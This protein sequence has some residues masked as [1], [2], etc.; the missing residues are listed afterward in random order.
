MPIRTPTAL[1]LLVAMGV[2]A[3]WAAGSK[4]PKVLAEAQALRSEQLQLLEKI[5]NIDSGTGDVAGGIKVADVLIPRLKALGMTVDSV[6]AEEPDL[7]PNTVATLKGTGKGC[8]LMVGHIDTVFEPG[9]AQRRP[10]RTDDKRAY[11]P[12]VADEKAGVVEGIYAL[13]ILRKLG[14]EDFKQIVFLVETS[15]ERGSPGTRA[16]IGKLLADADVELNLEPG[17][18]PDKITVWRKGSAFFFINVKGRAAHSGIAPQEGRNA[19]VELIHQLQGIEAFPHSGEGITV[20]LTIMHAGTR[21]N[22]IP[23]NATAEINLRVRDPADFDRVEQV[24]RRNAET[25]IVPDTRVTV[26]RATAFPPFPENPETN[27]LAALA[28]S[29]YAGMGRKLETGWNGGASE[30]GLAAEAG[31]PALDG[32][33]PAGGGYHSDQEYLSLDTISPRLYLLT[34]LLMELGTH[35]PSHARENSAR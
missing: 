7:A 28:Q 10:Y 15:E 23:E 8:I 2:S 34:R 33:G 32:L 4:N 5:V 22:I 13:E 12:G 1:A 6:P 31:V 35:P 11:G 24:L 21:N 9:T 25:T 17:D 3:S 20:N 19:A 29:L 26:T 18:P 30:S 27:R 16:L 14:F